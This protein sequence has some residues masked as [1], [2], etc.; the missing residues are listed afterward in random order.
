MSWTQAV[1]LQVA[2]YSIYHYK[3][4]R[5]PILFTGIIIV[6]NNLV[7]SFM[8]MH[9]KTLVTNED[10][11]ALILKLVRDSKVLNYKSCK[12]DKIYKET[13]DSLKI[14]E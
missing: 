11:A 4:L 13:S 14:K 5:S 7:Y 12:Y 1:P 2:Q 10:S 3:T 9:Q 6:Y 8:S